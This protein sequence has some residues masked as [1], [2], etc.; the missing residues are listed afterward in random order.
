[1]CI[2]SAVWCE[3]LTSTSSL[4]CSR[5]SVSVPTVFGLLEVCPT[6]FDLTQKDSGLFLHSQCLPVKLVRENDYFE[7]KLAFLESKQTRQTWTFFFVLGHSVPKHQSLVHALRSSS[8]R[9]KPYQR[10]VRVALQAIPRHLVRVRGWWL[11]VLWSLDHSGLF[12]YS[13]VCGLS[14]KF[15]TRVIWV[16]RVE[17][18]EHQS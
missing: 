8:I 11:V 15:A 9:L 7:F 14:C 6:R 2:Q 4:Q 17:P 18:L 5:H 3:A 1:M 16:L 13:N 10:F 12:L